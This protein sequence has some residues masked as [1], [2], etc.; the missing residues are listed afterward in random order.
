MAHTIKIEETCWKCLSSSTVEVQTSDLAAW[1]HG[2]LAQN[3]FPY[4]SVNERELLI[5]G[6]CGEC[7]DEMFPEEEEL[8]C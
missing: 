1:Q 8:E 3:A 6:T 4:L 7:F 5:S 2:E